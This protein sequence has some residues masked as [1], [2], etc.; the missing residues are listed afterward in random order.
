MALKLA[1]WRLLAAS[2]GGIGAATLL[3]FRVL[4]AS[5]TTAALLM[6]LIVLLTAT[7]TRLPFAIG[8]ALFATLCLDFFFLPPIGSVTISD[9]QN[10]ISLLV[11]CSVS[12]IAGRLSN[13]L[14]TQRDTVVEQQREA[15]R[16]HALN[17]LLLM[18]STGDDMRRR[19][20]NGCTQLFE[21][22]D[23]ALF[24]NLDGTLHH[25]GN[26]S[27]LPEEAMRTAST[28]DAVSV[29]D[30]Q[31][32]VVPV[33]LGNLQFGSMAYTRRV[34]L[35]AAT[36][37]ALGGAVALG[38]AQTQAQEAATR[39]QVVHRSEELKSVMIDALA[40]DLKTPLT[41]IE[42]AAEML[43]RRG[44]LST[45]QTNDM[46]AVIQEETRGLRRL[47]DEA[48]HLARIDAKR[49]KLNLQPESV[50]Q[51]VQAGIQ[52]LGEKSGNSRIQTS[53]EPG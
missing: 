43:A 22:D 41:S 48:T 26:R 16:L 49:F 27:S 14:R 38:L 23:F 19:I 39:S 2:L 34:P 40:H 6:L 53:V 13:Q 42:A 50:E 52:S 51:L 9:F 31:W 29:L 20:V 3:C 46:V 1:G 36:I 10:W 17:R 35:P 7:S 18:S 30:M 24:E 12:L 11:F 4:H 25:S 8:T 21:L 45:A 28:I 32:V 15:E 44:S 37:Q 33:S 5:P 47:V